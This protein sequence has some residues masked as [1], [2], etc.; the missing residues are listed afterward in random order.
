M[1]PGGPWNAVLHTLF[2]LPNLRRLTLGGLH[3]IQDLYPLFERPLP[4]LQ[5][6]CVK[7][8]PGVS[9]WDWTCEELYDR[10]RAK[11][12][13]SGLRTIKFSGCPIKVNDAR[14]RPEFVDTAHSELRCIKFPAMTSDR[15]AA[16][17]LAKCSNALA[18]IDTSG[19]HL[20]QE[21][22]RVIATKCTSL[23]AFS[24]TV[25]STLYD[26]DLDGLASLIEMRGPQLVCLTLFSAHQDT[27][28]RRI[29]QLMITHCRSLEALLL[30]ADSEGEFE[31]DCLELISRGGGRLKLLELHGSDFVIHMNTLI[32]RVADSCPKLEAFALP[33]NI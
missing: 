7:G 11:T 29:M 20:S 6:L 30:W 15:I 16:Q 10:G 5:T 18:A 24:V 2:L 26:D 13:F 21:T 23:K 14:E 9:A 1:N 28:P 3:G 22:L 27:V 25:E 12:F 19:V 4:S 17:F 31:D 8:N 33:F 32:N